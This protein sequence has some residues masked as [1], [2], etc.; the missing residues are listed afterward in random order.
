MSHLMN[1][2]A[3]L[4]V[5]FSHGDGS[6]VTD[7]DG[8][9][10][11]DACRELPCRRSGITTRRWS[12]RSRPGR[13]PAA[14]VEPLPH[15]AAGATG[16]QAGGAVGN[17]RGL[18][19]QLGLRGQRSGDQAGALYGHQQGYRQPA[20]VV[21]EKAFHGRTM[22]TLSAT[23]NRKAQAGFEPLVS[24]FVRVPY[25]DLEAIRAVAST[26]RTSSR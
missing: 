7:T 4:P 5:A 18:L 9:V 26:T 25:N 11:L 10:Y 12:R 20:I 13:A 3:R 14:F 21:M 15:S 1:T 6:W 17:G 19:L 24:G 2:Y 8:K 23:G 16:R 22:A